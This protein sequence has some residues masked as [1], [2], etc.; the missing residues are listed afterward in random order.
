M[1]FNICKKLVAF[2]ALSLMIAPSSVFA[3]EEGRGLERSRWSIGTLDDYFSYVNAHDLPSTLIIGAGRAE[4]YAEE[5]YEDAMAYF[6]VDENKI[7]EPDYRCD[8]NDMER[9]SQ[10]G[11]GQWDIIVLEGLPISIY[12]DGT[13][14]NN[15]YK[16]LKNGGQITFV[17]NSKWIMELYNDLGPRPYLLGDL[18]HV[19]ERCKAAHTALQLLE[20][21]Y[22]RNLYLSKEAK[23]SIIENAFNFDVENKSFD[24]SL[25]MAGAFL[26]MK[27]YPKH[28]GVEDLRT[29]YIVC[30]RKLPEE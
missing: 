23:V 20:T 6:L 24:I 2:L 21:S 29:D 10:L 28:R 30:I 19:L 25:D 9:L 4:N 12:L 7:F 26:G 14:I 22:W 3:S 5:N 1:K 27:Y 17:L 11:L 18:A 15:A 13:G 16:L 8:I